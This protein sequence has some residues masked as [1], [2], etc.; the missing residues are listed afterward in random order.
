M[1]AF[2]F[3]LQHRPQVSLNRLQF[4]SC[5]YGGC[6]PLAAGRS[7]LATWL[8]SLI[9]VTAATLMTV[10]VTFAPF[11]AYA[12]ARIPAEKDVAALI[13]AA[14][15]DDASGVRNMLL[16]GIDPNVTDAGGEPVLMRALRDKAY[17]AVAVLMDHPGL[18]VKRANRMRETPLMLAAWVGHQPLVEQFIK[19]GAEVN[20]PGWT[21]LHY[22]A[23]NGHDAVVALLLERYAFIDAQSPN[24]TTP[25]MMAV[26]GNHVST[27]RLLLDEGADVNMKNQL[28]MSLLDFAE[29]QGNTSL[30]DAL[31]ERAKRDADRKAR[32]WR[33]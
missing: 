20:Q 5:Q 17:R 8:G 24:L 16:R 11:S 27:V 1:F 26:R 21:P 18:D 14:R 31:R 28:G 12:Q 23:A 13:D 32:P 30:V 6:N 22:A 15:A 10:L 9:F 33:Y 19:R 7:P 4:R 29:K 2:T 3:I 25:L